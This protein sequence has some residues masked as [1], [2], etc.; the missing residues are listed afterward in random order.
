MDAVTIL[1][2]RPPMK[3]L[4]KLIRYGIKLRQLNDVPESG[5]RIGH[6]EPVETRL[7]RFSSIGSS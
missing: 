3:E 2:G 7:H 1:L 5:R 6:H 4:A